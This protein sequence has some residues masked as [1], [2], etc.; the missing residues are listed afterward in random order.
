MKIEFTKESFSGV[1]LFIGSPMYGG[2]CMVNYLKGMLDLFSSS[3]Q[4][5]IPIEMHGTAS[6]SLIQ[7]ARN[8]SAN[9]FM[10]SDS[11]H[12]L[13][14]DADIGFT[15]KDALTLLHLMA[16]DTEKKYDILAGPY[17]KK[18]ISW[19][20]IKRA[21]EKGLVQENEDLLK[22]YVG[23]YF[24]ST[25]SSSYSLQDPVEV[26]T[27]GTG[28][29][30]IPRRTFDKVMQAKPHNTYKNSSG[31]EGYAFFDCGID[32]ETKQYLSEDYLFCQEVRKL[33]GKVWIAPWLKLTHQGMYTFEGSME[34]IH[35]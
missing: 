8:I 5:E 30:M 27:V 33:G 16:T 12:F 28:F 34:N 6:E 10:K 19:G 26:S 3:I 31:E 9:Q 13:F 35:I 18:K 23:D 17:P 20:K 7:R 24:F 15:G 1:K 14:I 32:P 22:S 11:S 4:Y 29:M 21:V 25:T 2:M